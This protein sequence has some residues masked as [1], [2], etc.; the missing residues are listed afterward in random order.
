METLKTGNGAIEIAHRG[1][2]ISLNIETTEGSVEISLSVVETSQFVAM[3]HKQINEAA[4]E[5]LRTKS[6]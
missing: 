4:I 2:L 5:R 1:G 3:L 6:T